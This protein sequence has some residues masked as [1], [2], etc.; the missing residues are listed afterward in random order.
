MRPG[1]LPLFD[2]ILMDLF[3]PP[4]GAAVWAFLVRGWAMTVQGGE[5]SELTRQRQKKEFWIILIVA[6]LLMFGITIY[7]LL[8]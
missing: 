7:G 4:L 6:Y 2:Q 3:I 8:T 5:V 1:A